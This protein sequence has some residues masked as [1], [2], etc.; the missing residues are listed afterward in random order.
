MWTS[1]ICN[2]TNLY[3]TYSISSWILQTEEVCNFV[4]RTL[5]AQN[6]YSVGL[7]FFYSTTKKLRFL[8]I[9]AHVFAQ[10]PEGLHTKCYWKLLSITTY[11]TRIGNLYHLTQRAHHF[12]WK[13]SFTTKLF[14]TDVYPRIREHQTVSLSAEVASDDVPAKV[15]IY[16]VWYS[17]SC[18]LTNR[19]PVPPDLKLDTHSLYRVGSIQQKPSSNNDGRTGLLVIVNEWVSWRFPLA[20]CKCLDCTLKRSTTASFQILK[21]H[22]RAWFIWKRRE[23]T[24]KQITSHLTERVQ[25]SS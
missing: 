21:Y 20:P 8:P 12:I 25:R 16:F 5:G 4:F 24:Q 1:W 14:V 7:W 18:S 15:L 19:I 3:H 9:Q 10:K 11:H 6:G 13:L 23:I 22:S 17:H 2:S